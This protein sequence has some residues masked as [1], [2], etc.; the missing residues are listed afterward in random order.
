MAGL[1]LIV[2]AAFRCSRAIGYLH[3]VTRLHGNVVGVKSGD[4]GHPF[5]FL[6]QQVAVG[7]TKLTLHAYPYL[8]KDGLLDRLVKQVEAD[9]LGDLDFGALSPG[10]ETLM[11]ALPWGEDRLDVEVIQLKKPMVPVTIDVSPNHPD[12]KGGR[13][14]IGE[15][16]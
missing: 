15:S 12:C 11:I 13:E 10:H 4:L 6:S 5:R 8:R 16:K 3:Q 1:L 14:F 9:D 7:H 2:P